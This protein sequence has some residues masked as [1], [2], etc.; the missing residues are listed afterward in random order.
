MAMLRT[1]V[2]GAVERC[3][4]PS[5]MRPMQLSRTFWPVRWVSILS[6]FQVRWSGG[7]E[8]VAEGFGFSGA[9]DA[10]PRVGVF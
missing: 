8:G 1:V 5:Y 7:T 4:R 9:G 3:T 2:E 6:V 10:V